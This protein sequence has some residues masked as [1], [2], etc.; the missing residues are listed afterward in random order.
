VVNSRML[1]YPFWKW[2]P[3]RPSC[4]CA[5]NTRRIA[6]FACYV[7]PVKPDNRVRAT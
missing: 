5:I 7:R 1:A 2:P 4:S 6:T 3:L